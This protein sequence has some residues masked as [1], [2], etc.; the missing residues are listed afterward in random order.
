M[1]DA[2]YTAAVDSGEYTEFVTDGHGYGL[3][4]WTYWSRKSELLDFAQSGKNSIGDWEMQLDF[5][6]MELK[7]G[8]K[9]LYR[10][11]QDTTDMKATCDKFMVEFENPYDKS[12][13]AKDRRY[14]FALA[15]KA[16]LEDTEAEEETPA[17]VTP[18][19]DD[20]QETVY[21]V[22]IRDTL[23]KIAKK[24]GTTYKVL[25]AY[26]GIKNPNLIYVNQ[27]IRIP[28]GLVD[29]EDAPTVEIGRKVK[30]KDG[31]V[32]GG[33][34]TARGKKVG[35]WVRSLT[36]TVKNIQEN[37]GVKEALLKEINSWVAVDS[38]TVV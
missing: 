21:T 26:N 10:E 11:L 9:T 30:I 25:A 6:D 2:E 22:K 32:F 37:K 14:Q 33:L 35:A 4:Q 29:T 20:P 27:K 5:A 36:H 15:I 24:F 34:T 23:S 3:L 7:Q 19:P 8:F 16:L 28:A 13:G 1:T 17:P 38:L 18:A 12:E 31:A